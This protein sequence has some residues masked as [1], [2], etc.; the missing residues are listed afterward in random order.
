M[1]IHVLP[2]WQGVDRHGSIIVSHVGP[3]RP[4]SQRQK[5]VLGSG[6]FWVLQTL[7]SDSVQ[8][9][10]GFGW[11]GSSHA[12]NITLIHKMIKM[13]KENETGIQPDY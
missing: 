13:V 6:Y 8:P 3:P 2:P 12:I 11:H 10:Q 7:F 4:N 1:V 5:N 9:W